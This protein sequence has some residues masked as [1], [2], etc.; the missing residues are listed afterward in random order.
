MPN[1]L[2][3][4]LITVFAILVV[5]GLLPGVHVDGIPTA[6]AAAAVLGVLNLLVKPILIF[7]TLPLTLISLGFF[8]LILNALLFEL[9]AYLVPGLH[10]DSF[11]SAF[12]GA[13]IV[14]LVTWIV[15][16][17]SPK[18]H[19]SFFVFR[20]GKRQRPPSTRPRMGDDRIVDLHQDSDGE[21]K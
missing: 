9:A 1:L 6:I 18:S 5:A 3:R 16:P 10:I 17:R 15:T 14:S 20:T 2:L 4:W 7:L 21:W 11:G 13:L 8:L 19:Q 12:L